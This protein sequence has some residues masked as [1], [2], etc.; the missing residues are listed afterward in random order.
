M[1]AAILFLGMIIDALLGEPDALWRRFPHPAVLL[2]R[3]IERLEKRFNSEPEPARAGMLVVIG[4]AVSAWI[5]GVILSALPW[6]LEMLIVAVLLAQKSLVQHVIAV[7]DGLRL[8]LASGRQ[9]VARIVGRDTAAMDGPAISRAAIESSAENLSDGVIAPALFYLILGLPGLFLYKVVNT[10]DSMIGHRT[11][12]YEE[13]GRFAARLDDVLNWVPARLTAFLILLAGLRPMQITAIAD[14]AALHRS[15]NAGWSE[16]AM[17][18]VLDVA[19]SGPR[20]YDGRLTD[21]PYI[22]EDGQRVIGP[23]DIDRAV[24]VLWRVWAI[25]LVIVFLVMI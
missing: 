19:L 15:V 21:D 18:H 13:F 7:A 24:A 20:A 23:P 11:P 22:H 8:S 4:L 17:A 14:D 10:A 25:T 2:G 6:F 5:A 12:R 3:L 16:A 1:N 9:A